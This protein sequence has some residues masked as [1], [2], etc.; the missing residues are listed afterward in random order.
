MPFSRLHYDPNDLAAMQA[1][2]DIASVELEIGEADKTR[3]ERLAEIICSI[4]KSDHGLAVEAL[5]RKAAI[6]FRNRA[7]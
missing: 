4:A 5:A 7:W 3:R 1:A 6:A 2:F